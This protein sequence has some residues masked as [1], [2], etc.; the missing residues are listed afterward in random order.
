MADV[1]RPRRTRVKSGCLCCRLRRKKCDER[2][3]TCSGCDRNKLICSW[4]PSSS[5]PGRPSDLDWRGQLGS[6]ESVSRTGKDF[7]ASIAAESSSN[8]PA[9]FQKRLKREYSMNPSPANQLRL[10]EMFGT[11]SLNHPS[12]RILFEH[13]I[14]NTSNLLCGIRGPENPFITCVIPLARTDSMIM[15]C[16][17]ALSGAHLGYATSSSDVQ[18]A[19]STHYALALRQF[20]HTLTNAVSGKDLKPVNLLLTALML[21][22]VEVSTALLVSSYD[23]LRSEVLTNGLIGTVSFRQLK[24]CYLPPPSRELPLCT[25]LAGSQFRSS[26]LRTPRISTRDVLLFCL[27]CERHCKHRLGLPN[28]YLRALFRCSGRIPRLQSLRRYD[29]MCARPL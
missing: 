9:L 2:K 29:G 28:S 5:S 12:S 16:V 25:T 15:D 6:G 14:N 23:F 26:R 18:L 20:K 13:Y 19:S 21:C 27:G 11:A 1:L 10:P 17:L 4:A 3:P 22:H 8:S 24:R 7:T